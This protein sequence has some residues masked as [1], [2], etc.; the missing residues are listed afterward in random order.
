M[1]TKTSLRCRSCGFELD[2]RSS[3]EPIPSSCPSCGSREMEFSVTLLANSEMNDFR[4]DSQASQGFLVDNSFV[5]Q[6]AP[7]EY[8]IDLSSTFKEVAVA[9]LEPGVYEILIWKPLL[10]KNIS[11]I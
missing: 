1:Q 7:G 2:A 9:E 10:A 11:K 3:D 4:E 6:L 8:S 5:K